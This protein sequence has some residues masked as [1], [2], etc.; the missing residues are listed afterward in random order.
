MGR[1]TIVVVVASRPPRENVGTRKF[2]KLS[3][4][5]GRDPSRNVGAATPAGS[6]GIDFAIFLLADGVRPDVLREL[7][8]SGELPNISRYLMAEGSYYDG[9]TVLPSVTNVAYI[10]M[11]T[12]QY[13]GTADIPGSRWVDKSR[14]NAGKLFLKGHRSYVGPTNNRFSGDMSP[15]TETLYELCPDSLA[16]RSDIH[17]GLPSNR[18]RAQGIS[19][20]GSFVS[21]YTRRSDFVD[22]IA[23]KSLMGA[24]GRMSGD[25]PRL[26]FLPL[27]DVDTAAHAHGPHD[28]RTIAAYRRIDA[29]VGKIVEGLRRLGIWK[30]T[31]FLM[32]SDH[33]HTETKVHLGLRGL[34]SDIGYKVFEH[35][36]IHSRGVDAAVMVSGNSYAN[37][38]LA[39]EGE[40]ER[41]LAGHELEGEHM[42]LLMA[43]CRREEIEWIAF[44]WDGG[45]TKI[46][47][48]SGQALLDK[49]DDHYTYDYEG[50]DPLRLGL[51]HGRVPGSEALSLTIESE[52]PDALEQIWQLFTSTRTGDII[53]TSKP[54]YD[55]W[56]RRELPEHHSSHGALCREHM[57]VPILSN[58]PLSNEGPA[59]TVDLFPT[60]AESLGLSPTKPHFGRSLW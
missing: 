59:R 2:T 4:T 28:R 29:A 54:G 24:L 31:H 57:R 19:L 33:G 18:N 17:R 8:E 27:V 6:K 44:R 41:P 7:A 43:L 30:R 40:W 46:M 10:P 55:L 22:W 53:V 47:S 45:A 34:M 16:V 35:P 56:G 52:F 48:D 11:L 15:G 38:Y 58:R 51:A 50:S 26:V 20:L 9:V 42:R 37:I 12:G 3:G 1:G 39:S 25:L 13:P 5:N 60:I 21:H 14:F 49:V 36:S 23:L 32:S